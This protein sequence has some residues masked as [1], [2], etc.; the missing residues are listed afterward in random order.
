MD[1]ITVESKVWPPKKGESMQITTLVHKDGRRMRHVRGPVE[2]NEAQAALLARRGNIAGTFGSICY[3]E[4]FP[5]EDVCL[6]CVSIEDEKTISP[7]GCAVSEWSTSRPHYETGVRA[8][9]C[10]AC[11][12]READALKDRYERDLRILRAG[13][14]G[15]G[16]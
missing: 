4:S 3:F 11:Q 15:A 12:K 7:N 14:K 6:G 13:T 10:A 5:G 16:E 1:T 9:Y 2:E 8:G